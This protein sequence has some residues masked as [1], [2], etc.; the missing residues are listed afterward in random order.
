METEEF[1][2]L[3]DANPDIVLPREVNLLVEKIGERN[4]ELKRC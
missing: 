1:F 2:K 3:L 4:K